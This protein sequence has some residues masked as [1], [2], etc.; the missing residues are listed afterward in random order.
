[1]TPFF[2]ILI[3]AYN[4]QYSIERCV[5]SVTSQSFKDIEIIIVND[6]STDLTLTK[7]KK[8]KEEDDR[9]IVISNEENKSLLSSRLAGMKKEQGEYV[10][11]LDAD[12]YMDKNTCKILRKILLKNDV[13]IIEF[14]Y[15][16]EPEG[17]VIAQKKQPC[18]MVEAICK[19]LY[20]HT[21][22]N[23]CYKRELVAKVAEN[24]KEFYCNMT[25]DVY[26][27]ALFA[28]YARSYVQITDILYH[29]SNG[30]MSTKECLSED[31][32][33]NNII[34]ASE[35][36]MNL[37]GFLDN[38]MENG[39]ILSDTA[40]A[41]ALIFVRDRCTSFGY[42]LDHRLIVNELNNCTLT[43]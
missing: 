6:G 14:A 7:I 17:K 4:C 38:N 1:M 22:W 16:R 24:S 25:E 35:M 18:E 39:E 37:A 41:G 11:F 19:G 33:K 12:D 5:E 30:G 21:V 26:F 31:E 3:S 42:K 20:P 43:L 40:Y 36:K 13:D 34:S 9:I 27:S 32:V 28:F 10:L 8:I 2:R 15:I 23:K 29:Y